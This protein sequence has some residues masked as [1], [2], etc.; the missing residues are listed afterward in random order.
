MVEKVLAILTQADIEERVSR[1]GDVTTYE[2]FGNF[3]AKISERCHRIRKIWADGK[4]VYDKDADVQLEGL[5]CPSELG[6]ELKVREM[7]LAGYGNR[8]PQ[9][10]VGVCSDKPRN[11]G[12]I[13][14]VAGWTR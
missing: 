2:Y 11:V 12:S 4:L 6:T 1:N 14:Q 5:W 13:E 9:L 10:V 3:T 8:I 7:P